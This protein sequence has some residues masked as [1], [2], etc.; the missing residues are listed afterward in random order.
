VASASR[1]KPGYQLLLGYLL[2]LTTALAWGISWLT[3]RVARDLAPPLTETWGRYIVAALALL[4]VWLVLE[5]GRLPKLSGREVLIVVGM[6]ITGAG[7]YTFLFLIGINNAP[8]GDGAVLTPGLAGV[9]AM[10]LGAVLARKLPPGRAL[11]GAALAVA[12]CAL[13]GLSVFAGTHDAARLRGDVYLVLAAATWGVYTILGRALAGRV[14]AVTSI[15]LMSIVAAVLM[16]PVA[17]IADGVPHPLTWA[18]SAI[19]NVLYLGLGST[20]V[21]FVT[22][23][24]AIKILGVDR[25]APAFGLVPVFAVTG[26]VLFLHEQLFL[27]EAGGAVLVVCGI[28]LPVLPARTLSSIR[29]SLGLARVT[30]EEKL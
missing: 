9:F 17:L 25:A 20:A 3:A 24:A 14:A 11:G 26:A 2:M 21:G 19:E 12:G 18:P 23:Y 10:A 5:R 1:R 15:F 6:A 29:A 8:V 22:F 13:V 4:P 27:Y 30:S 28:L 16:A 7:V